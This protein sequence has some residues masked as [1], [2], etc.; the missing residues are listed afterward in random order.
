MK[1][2]NAAGEAI[3]SMRENNLKIFNRKKERKNHIDCLDGRTFVKF[4]KKKAFI[5]TFMRI[6]SAT[7]PLSLSEALDKFII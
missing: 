2:F 4:K 3:P 5:F 1:A 7:F 6:F